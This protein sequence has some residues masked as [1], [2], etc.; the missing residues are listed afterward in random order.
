MAKNNSS[1]SDSSKNKSNDDNSS[2]VDVKQRIVGA[3]VIISLA[4]I[5]LPMILNKKS[6]KPSID[7]NLQMPGMPDELKYSII[8][9]YKKLPTAPNMPEI[10]KPEVYPVDEHNI[11]LVEKQAIKFEQQLS[12]Q[13]RAE[14]TSTTKSSSETLKKLNAQTKRQPIKEEN[15]SPYKDAYI[16]QLGTF[17]KISNAQDLTRK[18]RIKGY[19]AYLELIKLSGKSYYRVRVGPFILKDQAQKALDGI[20]QKFKIKGRLIKD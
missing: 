4:V 12:Q 11:K 18:L 19:K 9:S 1:Q 17:R 8:T 14:N 6:S 15:Q 10:V 7:E 20:N 2:M 16:V 13:S 5:F 3:I